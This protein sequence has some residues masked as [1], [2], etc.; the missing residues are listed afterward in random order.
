MGLPKGSELIVILLVILLL[1]GA[2]KL[3]ELAR[4]L[5]S[6]AREFRKGIAEGREEDEPDNDS[7]ANP[8]TDST[9]E[10]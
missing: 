8:A 7:A 4:S 10:K 1:F 3:P 6:S 2:R 9:T 5:G